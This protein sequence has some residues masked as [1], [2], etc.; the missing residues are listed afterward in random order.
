[1]AAWL[2][3]CMVAWLHGVKGVEVMVPNRKILPFSGRKKFLN[4]E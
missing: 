4:I 3:D 1:M 2:H